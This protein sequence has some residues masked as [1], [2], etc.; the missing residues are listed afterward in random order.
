MLE[1]LFKLVKGSAGDS[2]I[3][4]PD[5]PN[6]HNN[7][8]VAEATNTVASGLRNMVAGGGLAFLQTNFGVITN[9][10]CSQGKYT[11]YDFLIVDPNQAKYFVCVSEASIKE[12]AKTYDLGSCGPRSTAEFLS[13]FPESSLYSACFVKQQTH[14]FT[15]KEKE[16]GT[17]YCTDGSAIY[18]ASISFPFWN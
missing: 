11:K 16:K 12:K 18:K 8:V 10:A 9:E 13:W 6:E 4:N 1:E 15:L 3:N 17:Y 5:V 14:F 2:V 7:E